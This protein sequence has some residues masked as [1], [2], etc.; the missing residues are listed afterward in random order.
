VPNGASGRR[1]LVVVDA[2]R[3]ARLAL[4]PLSRRA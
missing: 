1:A 2:R 4:R 3:R